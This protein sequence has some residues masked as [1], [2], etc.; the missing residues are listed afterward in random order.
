MSADKSNQRTNGSE[1][2]DAGGELDRAEASV[3]VKA[4]LESKKPLLDEGGGGGNGIGGGNVGSSAK[5]TPNQLTTYV[6][7]SG[8]EANRPADR[9]ASVAT[10]IGQRNDF[11]S[12][13]A[14]PRN[15]SFG[16]MT[17]TTTTGNE[18]T[19]HSS[20]PNTAAKPGTEVLTLIST[21]IKNAPNDFMGKSSI[22]IVH[23]TISIIHLNYRFESFG[24]NQAFFQSARLA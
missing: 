11:G 19:V 18:L 5:P 24:R 20:I 10:N 16:G 21:W 23:S 9:S 14:K 1:G 3:E 22:C 2:N 15:S 7:L 13:V 17:N 8:D 6:G 12:V 4:L